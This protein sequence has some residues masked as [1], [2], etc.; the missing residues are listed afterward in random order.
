M[1]ISFGALCWNFFLDW[2]WFVS[3]VPFFFSSFP[4]K[5][6]GLYFLTQSTLNWKFMFYSKHIK[7]FKSDIIF[8]FSKPFLKVQRVMK[9][10]CWFFFF[11]VLIDWLMDLCRVPTLP[12]RACPQLWRAGAALLRCTASYCCGF[13]LWASQTLPRACAP[14]SWGASFFHGMRTLPDQGSNPCSDTGRQTLTTGA[15]RK[16]PAT[17]FWLW[18]STWI[19]VPPCGLNHAPAS[20][21]MRS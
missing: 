8:K 11:S 20:E 3:S 5:G 9:F 6:D 1:A 16:F 7:D 18:S 15:T 21:V 17:G 13:F 19:I 4:Q 14:S 2:L 10:F 12:W